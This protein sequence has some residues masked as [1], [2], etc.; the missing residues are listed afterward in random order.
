M[1]EAVARAGAGGYAHP[2]AESRSANPVY[3]AYMMLYAGFIVAP[4]VAG[5]DKF[6][7]F[8]ANWDKYLAPQVASI[9]PFSP[10]TFMLIVGAIEIAAGILVAIKPKIGAYIV[11]VWLLGII[12]NLVIS[13][14]YL[15]VALR[16][17]GLALGAFALGRLAQEFDVPQPA[18]T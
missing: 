15:D 9:L 7:G 17:L 2:E 11:G 13:G 18:R 4:I 10:H 1:A 3:Q 8:L 12:G 5:A 6:I 14:A 16:D